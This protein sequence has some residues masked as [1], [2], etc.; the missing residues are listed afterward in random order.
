VKRILGYVTD[1][2]FALGI[3]YIGTHYYGFQNQL[4]AQLPTIQEQ[5]E[6]AI[7]KIANHP[8]SI[9]AAGRTDKGVHATGQVIHFDTDAIRSDY[10][11]I[12]GINTHLPK[13]ICVRWLKSVPVDF[14][15]RFSAIL[16]TYQYK[17]FNSS[18]RSALFHQRATLY[19]ARL[20]EIIMHQSAQ[21]FVG[22]RDFSSFRSIGCQAKN[23]VRT[24]YYFNISRHEDFVVLDLKA[25]AFLHHMVR[26]M[27]GL[28]LDIGSG[29]K[30]PDCIPAI[31]ASRD[32]TKA[33]IT[34]PA[35]GLYL[36]SVEYPEEFC[37]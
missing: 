29:K 11:W 27:A 18:I 20:D 23:P 21:Y 19:H 30:S 34:A 6:S 37:L 16:R 15:A 25:N 2:R 5:L 1:M 4:D 8:V 26:N 28:L 33:S 9:I 13:D 36:T 12:L 24:I 35:D 22:E 10:S 32:R 14:H 3:E 31:L 7:S 17:I